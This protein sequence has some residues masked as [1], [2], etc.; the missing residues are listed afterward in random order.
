MISTVKPHFRLF[1]QFI[2]LSC[3]RDKLRKSGSKKFSLYSKEKFTL[4]FRSH[5]DKKIWDK[6]EKIVQRYKYGEISENE[7]AKYDY[8]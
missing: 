8:I 7:L 6:R 4:L 1:D 3:Q 5:H 2:P